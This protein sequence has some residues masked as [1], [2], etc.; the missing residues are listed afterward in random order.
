MNRT[1]S[2][3]H[4]LRPND[5]DDRLFWVTLAGAAVIFLLL[6]APLLGG[7]VY[8]HDDLARYHLPFRFFYAE[9][10]AAG[11]SF[12]WLPNIYCG[13]YIHGDGSAGMGHPL[14]LLL[15]R[16]LPFA[17]AFNIELLINYP[18]MLA[19]MYLFLRRWKIP[20]D[21]GMLGALVFTF[22]GFNMLHYMHMNAVAVSAHIPWLLLAIDVSVR[23][24]D[25]RRAALGRLGV[26][27]LTA[28][29]LLLGH[30]QIFWFSALAEFLYTLVLVL[31]GGNWRRLVWLGI[32]KALGIIIGGFQLLPTWDA[33]SNSSRP[34]TFSRHSPMVHPIQAVQLVAPYLFN[35]IFFG[36]MS[37]ELK[38][39]IGA[40][41][42]LLLIMVIVRR[43]ELGSLNRLAVGAVVL[44]ILALVLSLGNY[45]YLYR[46]QPHL[47][48]IGL[49]RAPCRY[50]L[51]FHL[52][53]GVWTAIVF[54]DLSSLVRVRDRI[55]W[56]GLW[57]LALGMAAAI[58]P[59]VFLLWFWIRGH[60]GISRF[61][62]TSTTSMQLGFA[63]PALFILAG[64]LVVLASRGKRYALMGIILFAALDQ[65]SYG[66]S[67]IRRF[68]A[69]DI[70]TFLESR[71]I[72]SDA[73]RHRLQ[74]SDN[75]L[76]M[77]G[78]R[79]A[80]G[81]VSIPPRRYLDSLSEV[82][83]RLADAHWI[84]NKRPRF[85]GGKAYGL[86]LAEPL[87][88]A[89]L[90]TAA[91]VSSD[92]GKDIE[93]IDIETTALVAEKIDLPPGRPGTAEITGDRPGEISIA[94]E[95]ESRQLLALSESF[96]DGWRASVDGKSTPVLRLYG[97]FMG[98]VVDSGNHEVEF[99]FRPRSLRVG[100]LLSAAGCVL[101]LV[102]F[103][104]H[105]FMPRRE[106][107]QAHSDTVG[108]A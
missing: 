74:S 8:T 33:V 106:R 89:R 30:P 84:W 86:R 23:E 7:Y 10:L 35:D 52:A 34:D 98:C 63:G 14:H 5:A 11:D 108:T 25:E 61:I 19:G 82:R 87:P 26:T 41:P 57:P 93:G 2:L 79:L 68:P 51:L 101:A 83:L 105:A 66:L 96:H 17:A 44:G 42:P 77:R 47:P 56:R 88:R 64:T 85:L 28:S 45:G 103:L 92:P 100:A 9:S 1:R 60:P 95:S 67:Y 59:P 107:E 48:F 6:A 43:K 91:R 80:E 99:V 97:D 70:E 4:R 81:Y 104:A 37:Y 39:Y 40:I 76:I 29:E 13:F 78:I 75:L 3:F 46:L 22:S 15:Y 18:L 54:T 55:A 69:R 24:T 58:A 16:V 20:R 62:D 12:A 50:I 53:A 27:L 94:T 65:A 32:A 36:G 73:T 72:P 102:L 90:L 49:L 31:P 38:G 21:A 71:A